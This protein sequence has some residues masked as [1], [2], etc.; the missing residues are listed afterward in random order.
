MRSAQG[1]GTTE[2]RADYLWGK[3]SFLVKMVPKVDKGEKEILASPHL[4]SLVLYQFIPLPKIFRCYL[5]RKSKIVV[6]PCDSEE[7]RER[8]DN[9]FEN[10]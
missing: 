6:V 4:L 10:K 7:T 5:S 2:G 3:N 1:P 8:A 9:G